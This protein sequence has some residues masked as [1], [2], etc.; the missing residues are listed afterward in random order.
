MRLQVSISPAFTTR[1]KNYIRATGL[2]VGEVVRAALD[3]Y[4]KKRG[5]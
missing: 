1:V 2:S 5:H 3:E 4:L